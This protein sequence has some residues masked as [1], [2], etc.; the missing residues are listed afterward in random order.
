MI[1]FLILGYVSIIATGL[2]VYGILFTTRQQFYYP[3]LRNTI[4]SLGLAVFFLIICFPSS[5][6]IIVRTGFVT[7]LIVLGMRTS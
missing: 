5:N 4:T 3:I 1:F 2:L 6:Y 7:I